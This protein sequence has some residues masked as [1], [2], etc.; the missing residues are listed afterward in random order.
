M[1]GKEIELEITGYKAKSRSRAKNL[2][3]GKKHCGQGVTI[4]Y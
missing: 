1:P 4:I 2:N 3:R